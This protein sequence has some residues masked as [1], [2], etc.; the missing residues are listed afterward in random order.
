L[1]VNLPVLAMGRTLVKLNL[2]PLS[3]NSLKALASE[4]TYSAGR[5]GLLAALTAAAAKAAILLIRTKFIIPPLG[6]ESLTY[7]V[8]RL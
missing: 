6:L 4:I 1:W 8:L 7:V 2:H 3:K 5:P